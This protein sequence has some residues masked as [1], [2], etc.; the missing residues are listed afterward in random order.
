MTRPLTVILALAAL[1]APGC[2]WYGQEE[3]ALRPLPYPYQ[4]GVAVADSAE[5]TSV[6]GQ[7][8][9]FLFD[10]EEVHTVGQDAVC[11]L[12]DRG[13]Q[14]WDSLAFFISRREWRGGSFMANRLIEPVGG[15][16]GSA[17][18]AYKTYVGRIARL[19]ASVPTEA[20]VQFAEAAVFE[21]KAKGGVMVIG[22]PGEVLPPRF[23][24]VDGFLKEER[25]LERVYYVELE[26]LLSYALLR[27]Y[28][29][30]GFVRGDTGVVITVGGVDGGAGEPWVPTWEELDG[31]TFYTPEPERT[32]VMIAGGGPG[33]LRVNPPDHMRRGSVTILGNATA[34]GQDAEPAPG[35]VAEPADEQD[36]ETSG[37]RAPQPS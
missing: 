26:R 23:A 32:S 29:L 37:V 6:S 19:P 7:E 15:A 25:R 12:V 14:L 18:Y 20:A 35:Q 30:W 2:D 36:A 31:V 5:I 1:I 11:S 3:V 4:A 24:P 28:L 34:P 33:N 27:R 17:A 9:T 13:R 22:T 10:G 16:D 21:L 8:V